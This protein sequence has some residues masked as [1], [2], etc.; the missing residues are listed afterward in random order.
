[1]ARVRASGASAP[2]WLD[3]RPPAVKAAIMPDPAPPTTAAPGIPRPHLRDARLWLTVPDGAR[4]AVDLVWRIDDRLAA[5]VRD[6][7]EPAVAQLKL[8]WWRETLAQPVDQRP[9]GEPLLGELTG[10]DVDAD[11]LAMLASAWDDLLCARAAGG[12]GLADAAA[13]RGT[14]LLAASARAMTLDPAT[15]GAAWGLVDAALAW[16]EHGEELWASAMAAAPASRGPLRTLDAWARMI[17]AAS[18]RRAPLRE[19]WLLL[20]AGLRR[21]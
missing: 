17:A 6:A 7:R 19:G 12:D 20:R 4:A 8:A 15:G 16:P 9:R 10:F 11:D 1:M 5:I 14:A 18:G 2:S 13:A 21:G 3:P